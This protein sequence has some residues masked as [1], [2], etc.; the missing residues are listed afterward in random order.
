[1]PRILITGLNGVVGWNLFCAAAASWEAHGTFRK[2]Y[3]QFDAAHFHRIDLESDE[4]VTALF[5]QIKPDCLIH[6]WG[7]CDLDVCENFPDMAYRINVEGVKRFL[8]AA[9]QCG[10][11]QKFVY[12][13]TDHV[14]NGEKGQYEVGDAPSPIHVYGKTKLEAERLVRESGLP[15][16]II[17][18]GLVIGDSLQG[19]VGP[20]DFLLARIRAGKLTHYFTDEWRS[21][22]QACD[23]A[24]QVLDLIRQEMTG[25]FHVGGRETWNRFDLAVRLA[26]EAGLPTDGVCS[27]ERS[28]DTWAH[29][30]PRDLSLK[31]TPSF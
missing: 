7:I 4:E 9:Q 5:E 16:L 8:R 23:F 31:A 26:S 28:Q 29:I 22:I 14:F 30:R 2:K 6:S 3:P 10:T 25:I 17:R 13:S 27:K 11:V 15:Y 12:I 18:P 24:A 21:P 19:N 1:M 20:K